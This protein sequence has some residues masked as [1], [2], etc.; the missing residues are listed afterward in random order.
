MPDSNKFVM[1]FIC[2]DNTLPPHFGSITCHVIKQFKPFS[3]Q[4]LAFCV[5]HVFIA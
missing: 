3:S 1:L 2:N 4:C 5:H